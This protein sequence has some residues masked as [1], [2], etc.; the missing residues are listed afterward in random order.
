MG[1]FSSPIFPKNLHGRVGCAAAPLIIDIGRAG[2]FA[3]RV[4]SRAERQSPN[5]AVAS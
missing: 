3:A 5:K 4:L 1:G 2:A